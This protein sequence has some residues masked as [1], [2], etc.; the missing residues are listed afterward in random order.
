M[1]TWT[2]SPAYA[3]SPAARAFPDL[4]AVFAL[5]GRPIASDPLS[6]VIRVEVGGTGYYVKRYTGAGKNPLRRWLSRPRVHLEWKNL[7]AFAAWGIPT[8]RLVGYGLERRGGAFV[9]GALITEEIR[10]TQ[11]MARLA[12]NGDARLRDPKWVDAVSRQIAD[13]TRTLH[14][15]RFAHN[16]LKWRN[17]LVTSG[18][19]P[20]VSLIDCP[21][22][23]RWIEPFLSYRIVK[24]LACLD[25]VAK[26]Q[27][28]R[29]Q[30]LRFYHRY[31]GR[32]RLDEADRKRIRHIL[33]FFEGRE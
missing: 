33:R 4:D 9:R 20:T 21:S 23:M 11:D 17:L 24:D 6:D 28:S 16:D 14:E 3:D 12:S 27:L 30:R 15:H 7:R 29:T 13:I 25:K 26:Y 5:K 32:R 22:G 19:T 10:D 2:V 18:D 1:R 8:A 31:T